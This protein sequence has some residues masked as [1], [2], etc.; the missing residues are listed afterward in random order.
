MNAF[1]APYEVMKFPAGHTVTCSE[2]LHPMFF[3]SIR[4]IIVMEITC[5][6]KG[7]NRPHISFWSL[8]ITPKTVTSA[9]FSLASYKG[10]HS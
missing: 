5:S 10:G 1:L 2:E 8:Y 3:I 9:F 7:N 4:M 6:Y